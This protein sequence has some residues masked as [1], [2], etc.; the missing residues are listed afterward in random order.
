MKNCDKEKKRMK[1]KIKSSQKGAISV[2]VMITMVFFL[3]TILGAY[4]ISSKRAQ[5]Q[6]ESAKLVQGQYYTENEENDRYH[7][8]IADSSAII[9]IY[10]KEQLWSIGSGKT[11]E[12]EGKVYTFSSGASYELKNDVVINIEG[13][14]GSNVID[15]SK[16][17]KN[18]YEIYYYYNQDFYVPTTVENS[19]L[20]INGNHYAY[21]NLSKNLGYVTEGL[22][23]HYDGIKNTAMGHSASSVMWKD[24]SGNGNDGTIY[25]G[26]W[27]EEA[28]DFDGIDDWVSLGEM[29]YPNITLEIVAV[30]SNTGATSPITYIGNFEYGGYG[31]EQYPKDN[32]N[33]MSA[34]LNTTYTKRISNNAFQ[35]DKKYSLSGVYDTTTLSLFE[36]GQKVSGNTTGNLG[37]PR[38][39]TVMAIGA[40]P[41]GN[42]AT[43]GYLKGKVYCA[44]IYNRALTDEEV[45]KN[46]EIDK[47]RFGIE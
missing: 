24:L 9:P 30:C 18:H 35:K 5:T 40:N 14:E 19:K 26:I 42:N 43:G 21:K 3:L 16:I 29:N 47:I 37:F 39:N 32:A 13:L 2:F 7:S 15:E 31:I 22:V 20:S 17:N 1:R 27:N 34:Y 38:N 11:I 23:A 10:T 25:G 4:M 33:T 46:Y 12:I 8:K 44:R 28:L 45:R 36:N 41:N 6:T